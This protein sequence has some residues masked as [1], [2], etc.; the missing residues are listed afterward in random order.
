MRLRKFLPRAKFVINFCISFEVFADS[1]GFAPP[2]H[3]LE[4][5][6]LSFS[7]SANNSGVAALKALE[8]VRAASSRTSATPSSQSFRK[9]GNTQSQMRSVEAA[10][11]E[12]APAAAVA[13]VAAGEPDFAHNASHTAPS[14]VATSCLNLQL[15]AL[16]ALA[17][18]AAG[19]ALP[20]DACN[21]FSTFLCA[22]W[23]EATCMM[24]ATLR[25]AAR[26]TS[27][28]GSCKKASNWGK[29]SCS[30]S[31]DPKVCATM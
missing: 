3:P 15:S 13:A 14:C 1:T 10:S 24:P 4:P 27:G 19:S 2:R 30:V 17:A 26:R 23:L 31:V 8:V 21:N 12:P 20:I 5:S 9:S 29:T 7:G 25:S 16:A 18:T 11:S 28:A 6:L 22:T